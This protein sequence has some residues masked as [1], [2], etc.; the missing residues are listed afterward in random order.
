MTL[1]YYMQEDLREFLSDVYGSQ[2]QHWPMNEKMFN[3]TYRLLE[4]SGRCTDLIHLVPRPVNPFKDMLKQLG[5]QAIEAFLKTLSD[6]KKHYSICVK[7][8][9]Y[10]MRTKFGEAAQG[11]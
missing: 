9:A 7:G 5:K 3:L 11:L 8:I 4:K 2:V 6:D 10:G 1:D